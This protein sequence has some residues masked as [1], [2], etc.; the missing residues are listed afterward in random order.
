MKIIKI[1][2]LSVSTFALMA[3]LV[4]TAWS[5][6]VNVV[7]FLEWATPNQIAKVLYF[8]NKFSPTVS[9]INCGSFS[10]FQDTIKLN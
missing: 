8:L 7:F 9:P 10:A 5:K 4:S 3:T 1:A 6:D 2:G